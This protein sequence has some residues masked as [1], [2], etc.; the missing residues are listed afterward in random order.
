[1][2]LYDGGVRKRALRIY[3]M[4]TCS[5]CSDTFAVA[6]VHSVTGR[7]TDGQYDQL[8]IEL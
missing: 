4:F 7:W 8:Q 5:S 6:T 2:K 1:V 3:F